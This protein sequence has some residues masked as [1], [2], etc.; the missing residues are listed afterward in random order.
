M[1]EG[2]RQ[3]IEGLRAAGVTEYEGP[4]YGIREEGR[5]RVVLGAAPPPEAPARETPKPPPAKE[6]RDVG[7]GIRVRKPGAYQ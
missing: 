7:F 3:L 2:L 6:G 5:V 1:D 4:L